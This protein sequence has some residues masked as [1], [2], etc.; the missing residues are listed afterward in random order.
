MRYFRRSLS[1]KHTSP[2]RPISF[3]LFLSLFYYTNI[4]IYIYISENNEN[5]NAPK[6]SPHAPRGAHSRCARRTFNRVLRYVTFEREKE[7]NTRHHWIPRNPKDR[8]RERE[9][10][11]KISPSSFS[12]KRNALNTKSHTLTQTD[13]AF[14]RELLETTRCLSGSKPEADKVQAIFLLYKVLLS[15]MIGGEC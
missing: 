14:L 15:V 1:P 11:K 6:P 4:Y 5:N 13:D 12:F 8:E 9:K 7:R 10:R 2:R 3:S